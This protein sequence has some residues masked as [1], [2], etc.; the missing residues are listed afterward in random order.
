MNTVSSRRIPRLALATLAVGAFLAVAFVTPQ[1]RAFAQSI[2]QFFTRA[3]SNTL[4]LQASQIPMGENNASAP[5]AEPPAPL[6]SVGDAELQ[7]GLDV[8]ELPTVPRGFRF[9]GARMY[10]NAV[11]LEYEALGGGG[12]LMITQSKDGFL[13]SDWDQVPAEGIV[14]VRVGK[15]DGEFAQGTFVL[16]AGETSATWN[17]S[18]PV[19]RL[20]WLMDGVWFQMTKFGTTGPI[21][22]LDRDEMIQ[23]AEG[24]TNDP[25][26]MSVK[27]AEAQAGFDVLEPQ[28]LPQGMLYLGT[29]FDPVQKLVSLSYGYSADDRRL[30][31]KQQPV[32]SSEACELCGTVGATAAV[33]SVQIGDLPGEYALGVWQLTDTGPVWKDDP[34]LKTIRWQKDGTAFELIYMGMEAEKDELIPVAESLR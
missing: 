28:N 10:G 20:R 15:L 30:L 14:P 9:L 25:F 11:N 7:A 23:L 32:N 13:Q 21:E 6:I 29:S 17:S 24:I 18:A 31:I 5:T 2:L 34:Y 26:P 19:L 8:A 16:P 12:S 22:Y 1:G 33:E 4:P 27:D 3:E